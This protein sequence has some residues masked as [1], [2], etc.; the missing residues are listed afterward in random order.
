MKA[1]EYQTGFKSPPRCGTQNHLLVKFCGKP[2]SKF[3]YWTFCE[4]HMK[5][6]L[7]RLG[8]IKKEKLAKYELNIN[9]K[10]EK[11]K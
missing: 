8:K 3:E 10:R 2:G 5:T 4:T 9:S 1:C 7:S 11:T 6:V